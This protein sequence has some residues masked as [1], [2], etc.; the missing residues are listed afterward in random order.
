[1]RFECFDLRGLDRDVGLARSLGLAP[2]ARLRDAHL[3]EV[4]KPFARLTKRHP[5][6]QSHQPL[7]KVGGEGSGQQPKLLIEG[8]KAPPH[9]RDSSRS[10]E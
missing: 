2:G 3:Q 1:M 5:G 8:E 9:R 10:S 7:D 4:V 6:A